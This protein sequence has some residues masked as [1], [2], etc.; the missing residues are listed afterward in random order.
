MPNGTSACWFHT[1]R[2]T[3]RPPASSNK[4]TTAESSP[5][6]ISGAHISNLGDVKLIGSYQA[7]LATHNLGVQLGVK[8]PTGQYG[9][10]VVHRQNQ[11]GNDFPPGNAATA[12]VR[13]RYEADPRLVR[14]FR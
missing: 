10:A 9:T 2:A 1:F 6:Q 14:R 8:R 11:P 3:T 4:L 13:L 7:L 12:V 5:D